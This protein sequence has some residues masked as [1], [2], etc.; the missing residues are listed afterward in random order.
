[1]KRRMH[2]VLLSSMDADSA[3]FFAELWGTEIGQV[4]EDVTENFPERRDEP[5]F[6]NKERNKFTKYGNQVALEYF[7]RMDPIERTCSFAK[8][9]MESL[10]EQ[11]SRGFASKEQKDMFLVLRAD[12]YER[13]RT[14]MRELSIDKKTLES[15]GVSWKEV[16]SFYFQT[17]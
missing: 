14:N 16:R 10:Q 11:I 5:I 1:M 9:D 4:C 7:S 12:W 6:A 2:E 15:Y 13:L 8:Y 3:K 17:V